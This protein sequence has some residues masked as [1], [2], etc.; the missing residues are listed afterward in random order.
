MFS[1]LLSKEGFD[2]NIWF[3]GYDLQQIKTGLS[4]TKSKKEIEKMTDD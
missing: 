1:M 3:G 2:S 4:L